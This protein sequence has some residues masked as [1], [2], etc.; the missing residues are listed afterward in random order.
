[1]EYDQRKKAEEEALKERE[2]TAGVM[3]ALVPHGCCNRHNLG[4]LKHRRLGVERWLTVRGLEFRSHH[5]CSKLGVV[6]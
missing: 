6:L 5:P 4:G 2:G 3:G 1:M